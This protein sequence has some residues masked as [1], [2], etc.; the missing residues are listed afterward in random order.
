MIE[1]FLIWV[2]LLSLAVQHSKVVTS[3]N[4]SNVIFIAYILTIRKSY[5]FGMAFLLCEIVVLIDFIPSR[6]SAPIY[7]LSFY[8]AYL[9]SW[10]CI[11][12]VHI[13]NTT[14]RNTLLCCAI[15][16]SFLL[17]MTWDSYINAYTETLTW[18]NYENIILFIHVCLIIS[19]YKPRS[20]IDD[21]VDKL[22]CAFSFLRNNYA[23]LYFWYTIKN[24][25]IN[26]RLL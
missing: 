18:R 25:Q 8:C 22:A 11:A 26:K 5:L 15:M 19:L 21:M 7:G 14:N 16:I 24:W 12:G 10:L 20:I 2:E 3:Q 17:L 23:F 1:D 13:R 4:L 9:I 6:L